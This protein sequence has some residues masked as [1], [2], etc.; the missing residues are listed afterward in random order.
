MSAL[1]LDRL[2]Y[3]PADANS[4]NVGAYLRAGN[5]GDALTSTLISGKE[6][7]D[8]NIAGST[9]LGVYAEDS[10]HVSADLGQFVL[11]VQTASQGA[12][13]ADGD[14]APFQ[15]DPSGRLRVVADIDLTGDLVADGE[16]D[17]E[18]P[19]KVGSHS[20]DQ[21]SV[22]AATD[23]GDK[24]NLASDLYRRV[25]INDAPNIAIDVNA[26]SIDTTAGGVN[27]S[28]T[29]LAGRTRMMIQNSG[30][31]SVFVGPTGV[32]SAS[33]MELT[34]G[35]TLS[36]EIGEAIDLFAIAASGAQDVR[37]LEFA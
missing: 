20:Y 28:A 27:L 8:V 37:V 22:L 21:G 5:D 19:L 9:G 7:L 25:F 10:I 1:T 17:T 15:V 30:T 14:Y 18:D 12:L 29:P 6:S 16:A 3:D 31:Q 4:P 33:G 23:A 35:G 26:V 11:A 32:T 24:S 36:L 13:A 2:I 34:K